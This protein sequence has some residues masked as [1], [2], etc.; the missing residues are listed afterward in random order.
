MYS[1][2]N[3][4]NTI[5][6]LIIISI[7]L[8]S[9]FSYLGINEIRKWAD[10]RNILDIPN[11]RSS[12]TKPTPKGGGIVIV[13]LTVIG[14]LIL[15]SIA[16]VNKNYLL[17]SV[18]IGSGLLIAGIS[19]LDDLY[20]LKNSIRF[21]VQGLAAVIAIYFVGSIQTISVPLIGEIAFGLFGLVI[22]F[23]WL[24]GLTNIYN[25][26]DGIDGIAAI[27]AIAAGIGWLIVGY[28]VNDLFIIIVALLLLS[29]CL[30]FIFHNWQ[31]AK[32]FMGDV[33]SAFIG[34]CYGYLALYAYMLDSNL[35]IIGVIFVWPFIF[36]GTFT[37]F[38]R[39]SKKENIFQAHR[40]H[41]YQRLVIAGCSHRF[42]SSLYGILAF[43]GVGIGILLHAGSNSLQLLSLFVL[44]ALCVFLL[45]FVIKREARLTAQLTD[46]Q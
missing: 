12:H 2:I 26:M 1:E 20:S 25:F 3:I 22:T 30:G 29:T 38:R 40:S 33:G 32:I 16:N 41:I 18:F 46:V 10:S 24:T 27:Q 4:G 35:F 5:P 6:L 7:F 21:A 8:F 44:I 36:D 42:V 15:Y 39:L 13:L 11:E 37:L 34:F 9:F 17:L 23:I 45:A 14:L 31:P 43:I 19:Y 28:V